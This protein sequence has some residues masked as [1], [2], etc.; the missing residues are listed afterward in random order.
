MERYIERDIERDRGRK[1]ER[2]WRDSSD[3]GFWFMI[4]GC[5]V[6][7]NPLCRCRWEEQAVISTKKQKKYLFNSAFVADGLIVFQCSICINVITHDSWPWPRNSWEKLRNWEKYTSLITVSYF[8]PKER[9]SVHS[10][11]YVLI[12][13]VFM[14]I[15]MLKLRLK[16]SPGSSEWSAF[17]DSEIFD[18]T[19]AGNSTPLHKARNRAET[20][21]ALFLLLNVTK[22]CEQWSGTLEFLMYISH[23]IIWTAA[24]LE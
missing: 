21:A 14:I 8:H 1:R 19:A 22:N 7:G 6:S 11:S 4:L 12:R 2:D 5:L 9:Y 23:T 15:L 24:C 13:N 16:S 18:W 20:D 10:D 17:L 3:Y